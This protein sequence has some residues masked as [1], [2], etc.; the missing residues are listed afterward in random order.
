MKSANI[1]D[2]AITRLS[3]YARNLAVLEQKGVEMV[4][5]ARLAEICGV[6]PAQIRKDLAYFGEFGTRGLGYY[7]KELLYEI[8]NILGLE[9]KWRLAL[10]GVSGLGAALLRD[11]D[12]VNHGYIFVAAFE[13]D[14]E[15]IGMHIGDLTVASIEAITSLVQEKRVELGVIAVGSPW[16][17]EAA[18]RL[19]GAGVNGVLNFAPV[20]LQCPHHV[21]IENVDLTLKLDVLSYKLTAPASR[22]QRE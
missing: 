12:F 3:R 11:A 20:E 4:S 6:N 2:I 8:R 19:V 13:K 16:A 10:V 17:Q 22:Q 9:K 21:C 7:V 5:S 1:P 14:P 15:K 18:D